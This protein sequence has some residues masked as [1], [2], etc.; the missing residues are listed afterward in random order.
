MRAASC[1]FPPSWPRHQP[2]T[3]PQSTRPPGRA[4]LL[5]AAL[6]IAAV[7]AAGPAPAAAAGPD[8]RLP[9]NA[10]VEPNISYMLARFRTQGN[11]DLQ[12]CSELCQVEIDCI[13]WVWN[14]V[15]PQAQ[16]PGAAC[17]AA[18]AQR[19]HYHLGGLF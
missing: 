2:P 14:K 6:A 7:V 11:A 18:G 10:V 8:P 5:A 9:G 3:S 19:P 4:T 16:P 13:A 1:R 12:D 17:G 15:G